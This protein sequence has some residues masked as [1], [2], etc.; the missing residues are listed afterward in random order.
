MARTNFSVEI[1]TFAGGCFWCLEAD[2]SKVPGV[3]RVQTGYCGGDRP[4]PRYADVCAGATGHVEAVQVHY[5]AD[6]LR[7]ADL[8]ECFWRH[9]DPTDPGG[10]FC[11]RGPQ[12]RTA[13]FYHSEDQRRLAEE[14]KAALAHSGRFDRPIATQI[15]PFA[16]FY[17][18]EE[19]HQGYHRAHPARYRSYRAASGRDRFIKQAW[20]AASAGAGADER[21]LPRRLAPLQ[22]AVTRQCATEPP[23]RNAY[24]NEKRAGIYVDIVSGEPL[25]SS[26]DKFDSGT[27][28]PSFVKP[29]REDAVREIP[30]HS[31]GMLRVEVRSRRGDA[32]LGHVF[33]DGPAPTGMRY[34]INSASLR[35]I[36]KEDLVQEGYGDY[37]KLFKE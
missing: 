2:L 25:F 20:G 18:A 22:C 4:N 28:W 31:H 35:F 37:L 19:Y 10:Q 7:Y 34:C 23:F 15:R 29:L 24:W 9:I 17:A 26:Q 6:C 1:A 3:L 36:P 27:G 32:H 11:D 16:I 30:D 21:E 13:I 12:Y 14:S 8:L 5:D 33:A